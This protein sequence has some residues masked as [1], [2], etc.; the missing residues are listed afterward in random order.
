[1]GKGR[2]F[3]HPGIS[4]DE[5]YTKPEIYEVVKNWAVKHNQWE[6]RE[7]VRPFWPDADYQTYDYPEGCVVIDNPPFSKVS[8]IVK[9]YGD[10]G[11][12]YFLFCTGT[13][14]LNV[15]AP[16][17][18][19]TDIH[20]PFEN[21]GDANISFVSSKGPLIMSAPDLYQQLMRAKKVLNRRVVRT[22]WPIGLVTG[23][24]V[25]KMSR[26]GVHYVETVGKQHLYVDEMRSYQS[27]P[28]GGAYL[29][30]RENCA[31]AVAEMK[32]LAYEHDVRTVTLSDR[33]IAMIEELERSVN[34][35]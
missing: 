3:G 21:G 14:C 25:G 24:L 16:S 11:I 10:H 33:E 7:V 8:Q 22:E 13:S 29:V 15:N 28:F 32:K 30:P 31:K 6:G 1:M 26:H 17:H 4:N 19:C 5:F 27:K 12:D 18:V 2:N 34:D 35:E 20:L 23:A 9:W